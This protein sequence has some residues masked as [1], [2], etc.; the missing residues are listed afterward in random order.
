MQTAMLTVKASDR[1]R[2][3]KALMETEWPEAW[4]DGV[5]Q[6]RVGQIKMPLECRFREGKESVLTVS[7]GLLRWLGI[8]PGQYGFHCQYKDG[9]L[10]LGPVVGVMAETS[11][12]TR[13]PFRKQTA[14]FQELLE[15][16]THCGILAYIF[17]PLDAI[18]Q[19]GRIMG[20]GLEHGRW[21][22]RKYPLPDV[23]YPRHAGYSLLALR[24]RRQLAAGGI[25]FINPPLIGKWKTGR[26][27]QT[28]PEIVPYLPPTR[29]YRDI[30]Q[31]EKALADW[32]GVYLK[33]VTGSQG[34]GILRVTKTGRD[35]ELAYQSGERPRREKLNGI[36]ALAFRLKQLMRS[37]PY[38]LQRQLPL[39][40]FQQRLAD[41]RV[42]VQK[43][44]QNRWQVTG[45]AFRIGRG[46]GITSNISSGG[47]ARPVRPLLRTVFPPEEVER[48]NKEIE[49]LA[50]MAACSLEARIGPA[51]E[52]GIDI[53]VE[54]TGR[55]WFIEANL[56]PGRQVFS[57]LGD[58]KGRRSAVQMP[59]QYARYLAG[60]N[61]EVEKD[62]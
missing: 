50:L 61:Q 46:G 30:R 16:A 38:L 62:E 43:N 22:Q 58:R 51:G 15:E 40:R 31:L 55:L 5:L 6:L 12:G 54:E 24:T 29:Q 4:A 53:G 44:G 36:K 45:K 21:R 14:F 42:I 41:V 25:P 34:K 3:K 35:Y 23:V 2:G 32:P 49:Q 37:Q 13:R 57:L 8:A 17:S 28:F 19:D 18:R 60:F 26:I 47:M 1:I 9:M 10:A 11:R 56:K 39:L 48:I 59:L 33:P 27:L 52:F 20:Y 7:S